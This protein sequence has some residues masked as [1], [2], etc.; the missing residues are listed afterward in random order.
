[1]LPYTRDPDREPE[2]ICAS[3]TTTV[4]FSHALM[5]PCP[6]DFPA[7]E[8]ST[9]ICNIELS[10]TIRR[11]SEEGSPPLLLR[12]S[13]PPSASPQLR[14]VS[15]G[16]LRRQPWPTN[17][18]KVANSTSVARHPMQNYISKSRVDRCPYHPLGL[19]S[20]DLSPILRCRDL[21]SLE[22]AK[23]SHQQF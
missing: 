8:L 6:P 10:L 11:L 15:F 14:N 2:G 12:T 7:F 17:R 4:R 3:Y 16:N 22:P 20:P 19:S 9:F 23:P 1:M 13:T 18:I 21:C 5:V